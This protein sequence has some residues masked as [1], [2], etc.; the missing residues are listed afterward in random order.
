MVQKTKQNKQ[1]TTKKTPKANQ[2]TKKNPTQK[3]KSLG[4]EMLVSSTKEEIQATGTGGLNTVA[5]KIYAKECLIYKHQHL[6]KEML[7]GWVVLFF[8][9]ESSPL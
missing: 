8:S 2:P 1:K 9:V 3:E 4:L 6:I 5:G 7:G